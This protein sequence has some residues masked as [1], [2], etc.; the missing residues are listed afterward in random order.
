MSY[1]MFLNLPVKDLGRAKTFFTEVGFQFHGMTDDMASVVINDRCQV[2][3][4]AEPTFAGFSRNAVADP[5]AATQAI[6]VIAVE[7]R[8]EVDAL[9]KKAAVAGAEPIGE[10]REAHGRY[11]RGFADIDGHHWEVLCL[12]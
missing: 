11:Q 6:V 12:V 10:A 4:V 2:F 5:R 1:T 3:L 9:A 7:S 8:A